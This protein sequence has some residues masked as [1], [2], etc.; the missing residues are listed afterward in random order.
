MDG[1]TLTFPLEL[2]AAKLTFFAR[3][4]PTLLIS[5]FD[6]E[7]R[8]SSE[9][10]LAGEDSDRLGSGDGMRSPLLRAPL[11]ALQIG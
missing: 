7:L 3:R 2:N 11:G 1:S 8:S 6:P 9:C 4:R 10:A 5:A